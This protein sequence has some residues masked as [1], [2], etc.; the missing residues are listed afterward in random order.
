MLNI[1]NLSI[2]FLQN[3]KFEAAVDDVSF[4]LHQ[5]EILGMVG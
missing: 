5:N 1:K 2:S 4:S 3:K